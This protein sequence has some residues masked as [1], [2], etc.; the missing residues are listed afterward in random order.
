MN[1]KYRIVELY[2][3]GSVPSGIIDGKLKF[4]ATV[5]GLSTAVYKI[6]K[7]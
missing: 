7:I 2:S 1:G 5:A 6:S 3:K 4:S